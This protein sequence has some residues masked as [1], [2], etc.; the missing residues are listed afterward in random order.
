MLWQIPSWYRVKYIYIIYNYIKHTSACVSINYSVCT[1]CQNFFAYVLRII[2]TCMHMQNPT[3]FPHKIFCQTVTFVLAYDK[4]HHNNCKFKLTSSILHSV[5][6]RLFNCNWSSFSKKWS[7][8]I[9]I[10]K[11]SFSK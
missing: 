5:P 4:K 7:L 11:N 10:I 9:I 2:T 8:M 1:E 3:I 6:S